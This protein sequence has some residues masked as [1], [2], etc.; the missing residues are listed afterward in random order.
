MAILTTDA[1]SVTKPVHGR[2]P[3]VLAHNEAAEAWLD[4]D[5]AESTLRDLLV[6]VADKV[7]ETYPIARAVSKPQNDRP[8]LVESARDP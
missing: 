4:P 7:I 5:V 1:N 2:M 8:E 3:V 6:S